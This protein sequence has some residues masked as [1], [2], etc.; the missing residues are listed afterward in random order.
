MELYKKIFDNELVTV[1]TIDMEIPCR[2]EG[3]TP[4]SKWYN[5]IASYANRDRESQVMK[6][7]SNDSNNK[8]KVTAQFMLIN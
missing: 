8:I 4:V 6:N 3:I 5:F 7:Y 1:A 2:Y